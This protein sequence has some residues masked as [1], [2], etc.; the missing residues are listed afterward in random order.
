LCLFQHALA[1]IDNFH[2]PYDIRQTSGN[3]KRSVSVQTSTCGDLPVEKKYC[4]I[5]IIKIITEYTN[6]Y[7]ALSIN[8]LNGIA[9]A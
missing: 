8:A 3:K 7:A 5:I 1:K 4:S 6:E 9:I 2:K